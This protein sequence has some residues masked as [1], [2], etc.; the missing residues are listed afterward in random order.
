MKP[1]R[2][3]IPGTLALATTSPCVAIAV[4]GVATV[5]AELPDLRPS[6]T[7]HSGLNCREIT[8]WYVSR[9]FLR[10]NKVSCPSFD[11]RPADALSSYQQ[12]DIHMFRYKL[13]A[14]S[15][16]TLKKPVPELPG[17]YILEAARGRSCWQSIDLCGD[18]ACHNRLT[19]S[20]QGSQHV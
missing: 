20:R 4:D 17:G 9:G 15:S 10:S 12:D 2:R 6:S 16:P 13:M 8:L 7:C 14:V 1:H 3:P 11:L 19:Q 18:A 5:R